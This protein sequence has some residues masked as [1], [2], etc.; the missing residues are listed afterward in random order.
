MNELRT[1][2]TDCGNPIKDDRLIYSI[3]TKLPSEYSTFIYSYN[4]S[5][6]T[7]GSAYKKVSFGEYAKLLDEEEQKLKTMGILTSPKSKALVANNEGSQNSAGQSSNKG[8]GKKKWKNNK[9]E[10]TKKTTPTSNP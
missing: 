1:K 7:L 6:T 2:L 3:H 10:D 8:K 4:I 9:Q 5:K